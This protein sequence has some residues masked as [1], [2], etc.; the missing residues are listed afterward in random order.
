MKF[1]CTIIIY[2]LHSSA[3]KGDWFRNDPTRNDEILV[4]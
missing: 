4:F 2:Q 3:T 1:K